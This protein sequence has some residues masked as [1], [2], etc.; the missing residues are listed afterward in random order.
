[1]GVGVKCAGIL[2]VLFLL[3]SSLTSAI[4]QHVLSLLSGY[5]MHGI[6][7][8]TRRR[9][10]L[11]FDAITLHN[12]RV[13]SIPG[14]IHAS[15]TTYAIL[16]PR[17]GTG[18]GGG[19]GGSGG[20]GGPHSRGLSGIESP[21]RHSTRDLT[22][23]HAGLALLAGLWSK[24]RAWWG[25]FMEKRYKHNQIEQLE[26]G[27]SGQSEEVQLMNPRLSGQRPWGQGSGG[28][29]YGEGVP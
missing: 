25:A 13:S 10:C 1:V 4:S 3:A 19:S 26:D 17:K 11:H 23:K 22:P 28:A 8:I 21:A 9:I 24:V 16:E 18:G 6:T 27:L 14:N 7:A 15:R 12:Q 29:A 20:S 5:S 2:G